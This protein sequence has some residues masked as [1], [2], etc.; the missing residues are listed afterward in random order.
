MNLASVKSPGEVQLDATDIDS[1]IDLTQFTA[2]GTIRLTNSTLIDT[3]NAPSHASPLWI[4]ALFIVLSELM[5]SIAPSSAAS[6][7]PIWSR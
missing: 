4:I 3:S 5:A 7:S 2:L 6:Q 1:G